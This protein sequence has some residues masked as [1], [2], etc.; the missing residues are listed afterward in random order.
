MATTLAS[1]KSNVDEYLQQVKHDTC[2]KMQV[3]GD[4]TGAGLL[5]DNMAEGDLGDG[6]GKRLTALNLQT[7]GPL[8]HSPPSRTESRGSDADFPWTSFTMPYTSLK[9]RS[10]SLVDLS[11]AE[12]RERLQEATEMLEV[13]RCELEVTHRYLEGKYEALRILQ[14]K[15]ILDKATTHTKSLLQKSEDRAKALEKEVNGLQWEITFNQVQL[16]KF[17]QSWEQKFNR[18]NS[19][20]KVLS[21]SLDER[22]NE[23]REL[24]AE[25][26][27]QQ[28]VEL[29][30]MLSV[31][32][33][34]AYQG[35]KPPC[36]YGGESTVLEMAVL[37]ACRCPGVME[38][39]PCAKT[40]AASR[41]QLLQLRQELDLVLR[42]REEALLVADAFR[43]AFEQQLRK[44]SEH[45]LLLAE[46]RT[47]RSSPSKT[48]GKSYIPAGLCANRTPVGVAQKLR[49]ILPSGLDAKASLEHTDTLHRLL[50]LLNDKEEALA[51]QRKVSHML[52]HHAEELQKQLPVEATWPLDSPTKPLETFNSTPQ[53]L[54]N[55]QL[56]TSL[57]LT[58]SDLENKRHQLHNAT[59]SPQGTP[60]FQNQKEESSSDIKTKL[61]EP[62]DKKAQTAQPLDTKAQ[63]EEPP[64]A[65][66]QPKEL[67]ETNTQFIEPP[68]IEEPQDANTQVPE[69]LD[70]NQ[71][72]EILD[73]QRTH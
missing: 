11:K 63:C 8:Q 3:N 41:M 48:R 49:A 67:P 2:L 59:I 22:L 9:P 19:E 29:L 12:L 65:R 26:T 28:C 20:N 7:R 31:K 25:N 47:L 21:K 27:G 51:H 54:E 38:S 39:C 24:K 37:G 34:K 72:Q 45:F 23:I 70:T 66:T 64:D 61:L 40:A 6:M 58:Q 57:W 62:P 16:K 4:T 10:G 14:G 68:D 55:S 1:S 73:T 35:T 15:T 33:Q 42:S 32:E 71:P 44:R 30:S 53:S 50:D 52:A 46:A 36:S 43:I 18:V 13:L 5:D 56:K 69:S 60:D 17:E